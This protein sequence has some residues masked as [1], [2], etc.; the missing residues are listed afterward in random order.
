VAYVKDVRP[1][2]THGG[3]CV[4]DTWNPRELNQLSG[5]TSFITL[6][7]NQIT[8]Q[9]GTYLIEGTAPAF[10]TSHHKAKLSVAATGETIILGAN[11]FSNNAYPTQTASVLGGVVELSEPTTVELLHRCQNESPLFGLGIASNF[12]DDEVYSQLKIVKLD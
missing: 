1:N 7:D 9:P 11:S 6:V 3:G 12:G 8:L 2:G 10:V 5:D 4:E